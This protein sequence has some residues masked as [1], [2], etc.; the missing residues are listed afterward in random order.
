MSGKKVVNAENES[1][2]P[3]GSISAEENPL[4]D[5][6]TTI[7]TVM[8][9]KSDSE[10]LIKLLSSLSEDDES[11]NGAVNAKVR[12][13][14]SSFP[15]MLDSVFIEQAAVDEVGR[16]TNIAAWNRELR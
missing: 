11:S 14:F 3:D 9:T 8:I 7:P 2:Q 13:D 1:K 16:R 5:A 4:G 10:S 12:I 15:S 6:N